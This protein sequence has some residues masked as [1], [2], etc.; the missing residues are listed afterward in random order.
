MVGG[1]DKGSWTDVTKYCTLP[2]REVKKRLRRET[3]IEDHLSLR[4]FVYCTVPVKTRFYR[5]FNLPVAGAAPF[6]PFHEY[7]ARHNRVLWLPA[8]NWK[9]ATSPRLS[10]SSCML[11]TCFLFLLSLVC[12]VWACL[13]KIIFSVVSQCVKCR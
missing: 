2:A 9:H 12:S 7:K 8:F 10:S 6:P 5:W 4:T 1:E 13:C 3:K 11:S